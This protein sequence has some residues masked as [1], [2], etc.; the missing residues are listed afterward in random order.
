MPIDEKMRNEIQSFFEFRWEKDK[1]QALRTKAD[2]DIFD[3]MPY[4][5]Q[6][7]IYTDF[8]FGDFLKIFKKTFLIKQKKSEILSG[9]RKTSFNNKRFLKDG[10]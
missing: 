2:Q 9:I 5:V 4:A 1:T 7:K 3:Q 10:K 8:L 6:N